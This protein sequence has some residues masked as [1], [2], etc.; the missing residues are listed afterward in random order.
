MR[1][2]NLADIDSIVERLNFYHYTGSYKINAIVLRDGVKIFMSHDDIH[3]TRLI[4]GLTKKEA[5][6][7]LL[8][9][10]RGDNIANW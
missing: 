4:E 6:L 9:I 3:D 8:G 2:I 10:E 1:R 5:Y 7:Y